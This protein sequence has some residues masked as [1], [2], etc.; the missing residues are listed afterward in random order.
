MNCPNCG[1]PVLG[2]GWQKREYKKFD[3]GSEAAFL[4]RDRGFTVPA[5]VEWEKKM[6]AREANMQSDVFVPLVQSLVTGL[7]AGVG[8]GAIWDIPVGLV[9]GAASTGICWLLLMGEHR[10]LL[11]IIETIKG[12]DLDGDGEIGEPTTTRIEVDI[13]DGKKK[14]AINIDFGFPQEKFVIFAKGILA[15]KSTSV[16]TWTG[17]GKLFSDTEFDNLRD[18]LIARRLAHWKNPEHHNLGWKFNKVGFRVL[19]RVVE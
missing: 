5:G 9:I 1:F 15:G 17:S 13:T 12:V 6:P 4:E 10:R 19:C 2:G 8:C 18:E 3:F 14:R 11:W 7:C 16:N